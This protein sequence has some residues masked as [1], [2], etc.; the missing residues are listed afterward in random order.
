MCGSEATS[1]VAVWFLAQWWCK[2]RTSEDW[3]CLNMYICGKPRGGGLRCQYAQKV[4]KLISN[5]FLVE[6]VEGMTL[7]D[8]PFDGRNLLLELLV[9]LLHHLHHL[10]QPLLENVQSGAKVLCNRFVLSPVRAPQT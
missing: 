6:E 2:G 8:L 7:L 1:D 4:C 10:K 9:H 5:Q 3:N